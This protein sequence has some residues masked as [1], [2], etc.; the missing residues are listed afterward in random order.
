MALGI[1]TAGRS[2]RLTCDIFPDRDCSVLIALVSLVRICE[3]LASNFVSRICLAL[4]NNYFSP[5][6]VLQL[7]WTKCLWKSITVA[8]EL[9]WKVNSRLGV[10]VALAVFPRVEVVVVLTC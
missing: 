7:T 4:I 3:I 5:W 1:G 2:G 9:M 8:E 6:T 10:A